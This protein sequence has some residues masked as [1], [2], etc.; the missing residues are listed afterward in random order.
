[1]ID[2]ILLA[3][4]L[5]SI[6]H[7]SDEDAGSLIKALATGD[8]GHLTEI[9]AIVYPLIKGQVERMAALRE[10]RSAAGRIGGSKTKQTRSKR[11]ANEKQSEAPVPVPVPVPEPNQNHDQNQTS[12]DGEEKRELKL[13][14]RAPLPPALD[15]ALIEKAWNEYQEMRKA[16]KKPMTVRAQE[17][18]LKELEKLSGGDEQK[19]VDILNQSIKNTWTGVYALKD[20]E[21]KTNWEA[22]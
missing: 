2:I 5:E 16:K 19:A 10:K 6:V 13:P 22:V 18:T 7:L 12:P 9:A 3:E 8:D 17:L 11:E 4:S 1:M 20:A 14:K 15:T 21:K